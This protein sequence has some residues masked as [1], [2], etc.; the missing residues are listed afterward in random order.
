[1]I[2][3]CWNEISLPVRRHVTNFSIIA[4]NFK[5]S[6]E[7]DHLVQCP[8]GLSLAMNLASLTM[9]VTAACE[10]RGET[11]NVLISLLYS[12][13]YGCPSSVKVQRVQKKSSWNLFYC[14]PRNLTAS[15]YVNDILQSTI[16]SMVIQVPKYI[17]NRI[18]LGNAEK[19]ID[20]FSKY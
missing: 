1:M 19:I 17:T 12:K 6:V 2:R 15:M 4:G 11:V 5:V 20:A 16:L 14:V 3:R 18:C 10:S 8:I 13:T 7:L 9:P